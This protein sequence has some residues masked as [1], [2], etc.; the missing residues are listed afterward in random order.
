VGGFSEGGEELS[1]FVKFGEVLD[2]LR[3]YKFL[4]KD[5]APWN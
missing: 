3:N 2:K 4:N 5:S 1:R